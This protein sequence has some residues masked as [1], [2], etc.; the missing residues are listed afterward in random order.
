MDI[1]GIV[2]TVF[3]AI[4]ALA[5]IFHY[6]DRFPKEAADAHYK[7]ASMTVD[8]V[9]IALL[10]VMTF[11]PSMGFIAI[12]PF[13]SLTLMHLPVLLGAALFG[14]KKGLLY[15]LAFGVSSYVNALTGT[16]FNALFAFPWV[17]I[18]PRALFGLV[19]GIIFSLIGKLNKKGIKGIYLSLAC[20]GLTILHT[21]LVFADLFLFHYETVAGLMFSDQAIA[22]RFTF[23]AIIGLGMLGEALL[24]AVVIPP[25]H[26]AV[27][28]AAPKFI[29]RVQNQ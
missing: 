18:P 28:K 8:A 24:A 20:F 19:A 26:L 2:T 12:T 1:Y 16:G 21:V 15:G 5:L 25:L 13:L 4:A 10:L 29:S 27:T 14:W 7:I 23:A 3:L 22:A 9:F 6:K 17:A 11:V